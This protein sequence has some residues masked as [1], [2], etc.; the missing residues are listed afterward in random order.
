MWYALRIRNTIDFVLI[1]FVLFVYCEM[2][3]LFRLCLHLELRVIEFLG[4]PEKYD[5]AR[6]PSVQALVLFI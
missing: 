3:L 6:S 4:F 5:L 2:M 1:L